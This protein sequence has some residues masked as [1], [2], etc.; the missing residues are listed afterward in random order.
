MGSA[1]VS[2]MATARLGD[3]GGAERLGAGVALAAA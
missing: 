3:A 2:G 1:R